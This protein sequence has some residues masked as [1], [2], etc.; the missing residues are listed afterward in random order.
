M[1]KKE[2]QSNSE[3]HTL[4][5]LQVENETIFVSEVASKVIPKKLAA[6]NQISIKAKNIWSK[7]ILR[8]CQQ[9]AKTKDL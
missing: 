7:F 4:L 8:N 3:N 6:L 2:T 9:D 1:H 5:I